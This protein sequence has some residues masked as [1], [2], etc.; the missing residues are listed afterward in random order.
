MTIARGGTDLREEAAEGVRRLG[1]LRVEGRCRTAEHRR[2]CH[3][4]ISD[5]D[6]QKAMQ[7]RAGSLGDDQRGPAGPHHPTRT[8]RCSQQSSDCSHCAELSTNAA[9]D[10]KWFGD[11][12][13]AATIHTAW[14]SHS[15]H[16][17]ADQI[18]ICRDENVRASLRL[19]GGSAAGGGWRTSHLHMH[20][21]GAMTALSFVIPAFNA[22]HTIAPSIL[23]AQR[24]DPADIIVVDDGS[25]DDTADVARSH[26]ARLIQQRNAGP[27]AARRRF[28][29]VGAD[30]TILLDA[31]DDVVVPGVERSVAIL[32]GSNNCVAVVGGTLTRPKSGKS[33]QLPLWNEGVDAR[34]L[35]L[36][37]HA[38]APPAATT[39]RTDAL[40]AAFELEPPGVWPVFAED[41]EVLIR[42]ALRGMVL[43][44][45]DIAANYTW[46]GGRSS[47]AIGKRSATPDSSRA[48]LTSMEG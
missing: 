2:L 35:I 31:D 46:I 24:T 20:P 21:G 44:H 16:F 10:R 47:S 15:A 48:T 1:G 32:A 33:Y 3:P 45:S 41:Y 36:R 8:T 18:L 43:T 22:A 14:R 19:G 7:D 6:R 4:L 9:L 40:R 28:A 13:E 25:S 38:P 42:V 5:L 27:A 39:F 23:S 34:S 37:G 11:A 26:G 30:A 29:E 12:L 17:D